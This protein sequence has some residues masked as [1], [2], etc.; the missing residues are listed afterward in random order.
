M[1]NKSQ[2]TSKAGGKLRKIKMPPYYLNWTYWYG[3]IPDRY[4]NLNED[5]AGTDNYQAF[6]IEFE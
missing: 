2:G 4:G 5:T 6:H 3:F 1:K